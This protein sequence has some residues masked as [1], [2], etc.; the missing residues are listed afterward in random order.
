MSGDAARFGT[1]QCSTLSVAVKRALF[2][3]S[4]LVARRACEAHPARTAT[5]RSARGP[6]AAIGGSSAA[7]RAHT[8]RQPEPRRGGNTPSSELPARSASR[9]I[10]SRTP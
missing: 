5:P 10:A 2:A 1:R 7:T 4:D 9:S 8:A 3:R 6:R